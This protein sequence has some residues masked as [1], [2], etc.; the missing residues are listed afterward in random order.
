MTGSH[1]RDIKHGF[2]GACEEAGIEDLTFTIWVVLGSQEPT[3]TGTARRD[4]MGHS[5]STRTGDYT[6]STPK[7]QVA[8]ME[9][10]ACYKS[11]ILDKISTKRGSK[12]F[13]ASNCQLLITNG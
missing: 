3:V 9:L 8:A 12:V 4:I 2:R 5:S 6:H 10:V 1:V 11:R 7:S 13:A